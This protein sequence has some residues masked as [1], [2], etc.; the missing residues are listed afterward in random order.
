[1]R[2]SIQLF[3]A[4]SAPPLFF[5]IAY[6]DTL[7]HLWSISFFLGLT[8]LHYFALPLPPIMAIQ[9]FAMSICAPKPIDRSRVLRSLFMCPSLVQVS[10]HAF[11]IYTAY[12]FLCVSVCLYVWMYLCMHLC[13]CTMSWTCM[14]M[15]IY[16]YIYIGNTWVWVNKY[17]AFLTLLPC[18]SI[19]AES[20]HLVEQAASTPN[21]TSLVCLEWMG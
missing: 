19:A 20:I 6:K 5:S 14:Y 12:I 7:H 1:M 13:I 21:L 10:G 8:S 16:I 3:R 2:Y 11:L 17:S 15:Y 9:A 18:F 4:G